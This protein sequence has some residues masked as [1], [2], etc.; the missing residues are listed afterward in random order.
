MA[1]QRD[2]VGIGPSTCDRAGCDRRPVFWA[3]D[4]DGDRW[5]PLC[6]RHLLQRH[7]SLERRVWLESGYAK[8]IE[9]G[10]PDGP[11]SATTVHARAE[12]FRTI[13]AETMG[14]SE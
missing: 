6:D 5:H 13:V 1:D 4:G 12:A 8:P 3:Y 11:P 10:R 9:R 7:P 14:W 2:D